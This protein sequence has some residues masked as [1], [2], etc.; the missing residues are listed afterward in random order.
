MRIMLAVVIAG[1][2]SAGAV[3]AGK[4]DP[5]SSSPHATT[6][7]IEAGAVRD[8]QPD[9]RPDS[10]NEPPRDVGVVKQREIVQQS[11]SVDRFLRRKGMVPD[12]RTVDTFKKMNPAVTSVGRIP[13][14]TGVTVFVPGSDGVADARRPARARVDQ[15]QAARFTAALEVD[16]VARVRA[17]ASALPASAYQR[18]DDAARHRALLARVDDTAQLVQ[19]HAAELPSRELAL[20][21][22]YLWQASTKAA[23]LNA[24]ALQ[25]QPAPLPGPVA[26]PIDEAQLTQLARATGPVQQMGERLARG[27]APFERRRV[28]V[29]VQDRDGHN[30]R[31]PLRVYVLPAGL[32]DNPPPAPDLLLDLLSELTFER[33]TSPASGTVFEG[34]MRVW[35]GPDFEYEQMARLIMQ[36]KLTHFV[37]VRGHESGG[38]DA[39]LLFVAPDGITVPDAQPR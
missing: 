15:A 14:H 37:P 13:A 9:S 21:R 25:A 26:A 7:R 29:T 12:A 3:W 2:C 27:L 4:P 36:G 1:L 34:D 23:Q 32:I 28:T 5:R 35:V 8:A 16:R 10:R 19:T 6:V 38:A 22:Y 24:H 18:P 30:L 39:N 33:L 20:S 11:Q 17:Q 31:N